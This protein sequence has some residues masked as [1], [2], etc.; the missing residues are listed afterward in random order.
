MQDNGLVSLA[1]VRKLLFTILRNWYILV[2]CAM[3][4]FASG[5]LY[6]H[7][8]PV[9][10]TSKMQILLK[11]SD[12]YN[13]QNALYKDLGFSDSRFSN[14]ERIAN[15]MRVVKSSEII[16]EALERLN[17]QVSYYIIGRLKITEVYNS[18]PFRVKIEAP[19]T[20]S[21]GKE[22]NLRILSENEFQLGFV[23]EGEMN[24]VPYKFGDLITDFGLFIRVEKRKNFSDLKIGTIKSVEYAFKINNTASLISKYKN[25]I[26][27]TNFDYTSILEISLQDQI[28]N[29]A[30]AFLDTLSNV[31]IQNTVKGNF[32]RNDN[33]LNYIQKQ[34]EEV[35]YIIGDIEMELGDFKEQNE[36]LDLN[37]EEQG[38]YDQLIASES[39]KRIIVEKTKAI[40][41]LNNYLL[42][43]ENELILPPSV[44]LIDD[45]DFIKSSLGQ[46]YTLEL[47]RVELL[48]SNTEESENVRRQD[49]KV[50]RLRTSLLKYLSNLKGTNFSVLTQ[51]KSEIQRLKSELRII[52]DNQ[53]RILDIRRK[54]EVNEELYSYLLS[55]RAETIITRAGIIPETKVIESPRQS[56]KPT[57]DKTRIILVFLLSGLAFAAV[58]IA[59]KTLFFEKITSVAMLA[60]STDLP[61]L[62]GIPRIK[63]VQKGYLKVQESSPKDILSSSFRLVRTNLQFL[64]GNKAS[65]GTTVMVTSVL[66]S[67]GKTFTSIN[68]SRIIAMTGKKVLLIDMDLHKPKI[69]KAFNLENDRGLSSLLIGAE[70]MNNI[71]HDSDFE[72][73]KII[74]SGPIPPNASDLVLS[75]TMEVLFNDLR[76][77][78]DYIIIDTPPTGLITDAI[79]LMKHMDKKV[80]VMNS[81]TASKRTITFIQGIIDRGKVKNVGLVLNHTKESA[82]QGYYGKYSYGYSYQYGYGHGSDG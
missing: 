73:L 6:V 80:F 49:E 19:S 40:D 56:G 67:E 33:T 59:G 28:V 47:E 45:D 24:Y 10:Y 65:D 53:R 22:V 29:R 36:I 13:Y 30:V 72:E 54:L 26:S 32:D 23:K 1:E 77:E 8:L 21:F 50:E 64:V 71:V 79:T 51:I 46:I 68:L 37:K 34:I 62:G 12:I 27:I 14:Y 69:H 70:D 55:K 75:D 3:A 25:S 41:V 52:P 42:N 39:E 4:S 74:T 63:N 35:T 31:Y 15:E 18:L 60:D 81:K 17:L 78:F 48:Y 20:R 11:A 7:R 43:E 38:F 58:F 66:P 5:Y 2:F 61:V 16:E 82:L 9:N 57:P 44:Y 76:K